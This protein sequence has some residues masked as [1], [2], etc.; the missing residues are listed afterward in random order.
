MTKHLKTK[1]ALFD[2]VDTMLTP[3]AI[4]ELLAQPVTH[5][6]IL[7]MNG[8][9]GLAGSQL[10]YVN[11][12]TERLVIKRMSIESDWIM[13]AT[14]DQ[15]CRSVKLWEYGLLDELRPELE[16]KIVACAQDGQGWALLMRDLTGHTF[17]WDKPMVPELV[18]AFLDGLSRVHAAFWDEPCLNDPR[19]GL[20]SPNNLLNS[21]TLALGEEGFESRASPISEWVK[22]GWDALPE[23]LAAGVFKQMH[24]LI[25]NPQPLFDALAQYPVTLLHGDYR[26]ENFAH[27]PACL[28]LLDWQQAAYSIMTIDLAWFVKHGYVRDVMS[29]D[30]AVR[31]YR[32]RLEVHLGTP[33]DD[34]QWQIMCDL[35]FCFDALRS[36]FFHAFFYTQNDNPVQRTFDER[37]VK[38]Q[39]KD[40]IRAMRWL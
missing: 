22:H 1:Y 25:D 9:S 2:S 16:H 39:G 26:A 6:D 19:L 7:P 36:V 12:N 32:R 5:V 40:L 18:P 29:R 10:S 13:F 33:F 28:V 14:D 11:T 17:T 34:H 31:Y 21:V 35:G 23:L 38:Q 20:C 4:G 3:E 8:H 24:R 27:Q 15:Q 30:E 37:T